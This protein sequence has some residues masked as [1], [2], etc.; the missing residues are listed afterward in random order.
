MVSSYSV[1]SQ[2]EYTVLNQKLVLQG[3][4]MRYY[5]EKVNNLLILCRTFHFE[6]MS[7]HVDT[8]LCIVNVSFQIPGLGRLLLESEGEV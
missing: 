5:A 2:Y 6:Y 4:G 1:T 7:F 8:I 3:V